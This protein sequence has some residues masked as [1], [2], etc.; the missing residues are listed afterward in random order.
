[1]AIPPDADSLDITP[2]MM[3]R[4]ALEELQTKFGEKPPTKALVIMLWDDGREYDTRFYNAG[5]K[6]SELI[7]LVECQ[8]RI[9]LDLLYGDIDDEEE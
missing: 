5:M 3:L 9:F 4:D 8:K 2:E 7:A 1:M 6:T